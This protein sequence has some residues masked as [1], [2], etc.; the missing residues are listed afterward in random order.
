MDQAQTL[1]SAN[2]NELE[3]LKEELRRTAQE[4]KDM[5]AQRDAILDNHESTIRGLQS[6]LSMLS[7]NDDTPVVENNPPASNALVPWNARPAVQDATNS[8]I[9]EL[10]RTFQAYYRRLQARTARV[11]RIGRENRSQLDRT[12]GEYNVRLTRLMMAMQVIDAIHL[13]IATALNDHDT[14]LRRQSRTI[15]RQS[16]RLQDTRE[17]LAS[18]AR[19]QVVD[20]GVL[21]EHST[22]IEGVGATLINHRT[23]LDG[24]DTLLNNYHERLV[25]ANRLN[26]LRSSRTDEILADYG[27]RLDTTETELGIQSIRVDRMDDRLDDIDTELGV[28]S[29]RTD[30]VHDRL[31]EMQTNH[32]GDL[33]RIEETEAAVEGH[34]NTFFR[35]WDVMDEM[36]W[37]RD[38]DLTRMDTTEDRL[39]S[40]V[41]RIDRTLNDIRS[42]QVDNLARMNAIDDLVVTYAQQQAYNV[43]VSEA[44][45]GH[46]ETGMSRVMEDMHARIQQI[47]AEVIR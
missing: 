12:I 40:N 37:N 26:D 34:A 46:V 33:T 44:M 23:R 35:V 41:E 9:D 45:E 18:V 20:R 31:D 3:T 1:A 25:A 27:N 4:T 43:Q 22:A 30:R 29:T 2:E 17:T 7:I 19:T 8:G 16:T 15:F 28:Q 32:D 24:H 39:T 42:N 6:D 10:Q 11:E 21:D 5:L 14:V 36:V 13:A 47:N 38:E